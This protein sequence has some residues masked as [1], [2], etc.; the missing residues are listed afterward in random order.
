ML[1]RSKQEILWTAI[2]RKLFHLTCKVVHTESDKVAPHEPGLVHSVHIVFGG[3]ESGYGEQ[4]SGYLPT[5]HKVISVHQAIE[6]DYHLSPIL[7]QRLGA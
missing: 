3:W 5:C 6:V 2:R 7:Y 4:E 1:A